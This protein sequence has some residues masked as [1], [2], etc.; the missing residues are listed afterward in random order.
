MVK[1]IMSVTLHWILSMH[2][3][4]VTGQ[5]Y[6]KNSLKIFNNLIFHL[7]CTD[8]LME[9]KARKNLHKCWSK[10]TEENV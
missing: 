6:P 4:T 2:L 7:E 8:E 3:T 1:V 10:T 5:N 9:G